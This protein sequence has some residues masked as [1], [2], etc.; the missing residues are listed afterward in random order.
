MSTNN[1]GANVADATRQ[2]SRADQA[3]ASAT[4]MNNQQ[5]KNPSNPLSKS[6]GSE[7]DFSTPYC[8]VNGDGRE[9]TALKTSSKSLEKSL[10]DQIY[11]LRLHRKP[12]LTDAG[13]RLL[14]EMRIV[15]NSS[16]TK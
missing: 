1:D 15:G 13:R 11:E 9:P 5:P 14:G 4:S 8:S 6:T 2:V 3:T 16:F 12:L 10:V 7:F